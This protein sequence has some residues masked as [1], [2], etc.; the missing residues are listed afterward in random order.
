MAIDRTGA[1][2]DAP[3][4]PKRSGGRPAT[5]F[6]SRE[7]CRRRSREAGE[8]SWRRP[9]RSRRTRRSRPPSRLAHHRTHRKRPARTGQNGDAA[10]TFQRP[11][12]PRTASPDTTHCRGPTLSHFLPGRANQDEGCHRPA[13][14]A[15]RSRFPAWTGRR[16]KDGT[17][18]RALLG[19]ALHRIDPTHPRRPRRGHLHRPYQHDRAID[20]EATRLEAG[21]ADP[22]RW[23]SRE[24]SEATEQ[25]GG[26]AGCSH[27]ARPHHLVP[28]GPAGRG[29]KNG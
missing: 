3:A 11:C 14:R 17:R 8:E 28:I 10:S 7:E 12:A 5:A 19:Q 13:R 26:L 23:R 21:R 16:T 4:R 9:L 1:G 27:P 20:P 22:C 24:R 18:E 29:S 25:T 2:A 6:L 15:A